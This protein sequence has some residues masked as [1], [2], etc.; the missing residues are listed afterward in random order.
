[1]YVNDIQTKPKYLCT[2]CFA[3]SSEL[4]FLLWQ[5]LWEAENATFSACF[6]IYSHEVVDWM[7]VDVIHVSLIV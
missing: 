5:N 1:M 4:E 6:V 3:P 2:Q 7:A